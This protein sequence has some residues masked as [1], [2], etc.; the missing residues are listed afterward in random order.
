MYFVVG[1]I[2]KIVDFRKLNM[3]VRKKK[4]NRVTIVDV[5]KDAG[6]SIATVSRALHNDPLVSDETREYVKSIANRLGYRPSQ[7]AARFAKG[8]AGVINLLV[9]SVQNPIYAMFVE[10][11]LKLSSERE[12]EVLV[13][14]SQLDVKHERDI[15]KS[16]CNVHTDGFILILEYPEDN[17][18]YVLELAKVQRGRPI[19]LRQDLPESAPFDSACADFEGGSYE[20]TKY[21]LSLG[22][23]EIRFVGYHL[24]ESARP[25]GF[26]KALQEMGVNVGEEKFIRCGPGIEDVYR[27]TYQVLSKN[28][29][30]TALVVQSD[31]YAFGVL[32]AISELGLKVPDDISLGSFDGIEFS[33]YGYIPLTTMAQPVKQIVESLVDQLFLRMEDDSCPVKHVKFPMNLVVRRTTGPV[34]K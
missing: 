24:K 3:R 32:R 11:I 13:S 21:L 33:E 28:S 1:Q 15:I 16:F 29:Q 12:Y 10:E 7:I 17:Y 20:V 23:R 2:D 19:V 34:R 14:Y 9:P 31:Y 26:M 25:R 18:Q 27:T 6:V 5:A 4:T 8:K 22:H 30:I